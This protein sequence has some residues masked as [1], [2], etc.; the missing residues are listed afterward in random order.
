MRPS[1][2]FALLALTATPALAQQTPTGLYRAQAGP[3]VASA[4]EIAPDGRFRYQRSEG[5]LD[6]QASGRWTQT[7][8]GATLET[9]PHPRAPEWQINTIAEAKDSPLTVMVRV[10]G[11]GP[12]GLAGIYLRIGFANGDRQAGMT[13][14]DGWQMD[15]AET[16]QPIWIEF[17]EPIHGVTSQRFDLPK[18]GKMALTVTLVPNDIGIAA[19]DK[20]PVT[21]TKD[22]IVLHWRGQD[23]AYARAKNRPSGGNGGGLTIR[24]GPNEQ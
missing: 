12:D 4:L 22:G 2:T 6:E 10:P 18:Q 13:Q 24:V 20:T 14:Y 19:F 9:L 3:D 16:R 17:S 23:I 8:E 21:M 5:A 15:P 1:L 11:G 7:P